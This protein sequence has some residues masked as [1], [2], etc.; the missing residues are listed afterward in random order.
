MNIIK[1]HGFHEIYDV[2]SKLSNSF[3]SFHGDLKAFA[4]KLSENATVYVCIHEQAPVGVIAFYAN[5]FEEKTAFITSVLVDSKLK[6]QGIGT[7][8][9]KTAESECQRRGFNRMK[10]EVDKQ[11]NCAI[12][13]YT[14]HQY[15]ILDDATRHSIYM[16]KNL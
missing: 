7:L 3:F 1:I 8:L 4:L 11:N 14:K 9:L 5:R 12:Q 6:G 13:F 16:I 2:F 15:Q 10:L